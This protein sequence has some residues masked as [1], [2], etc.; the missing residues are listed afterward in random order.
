MPLAS[1]ASLQWYGPGAGAMVANEA[2]GSVVAGVK[3]TGRAN[4]VTTGTGSM[5]LA[6]AT[7]LVNSP[8][9]V[10]G[11]GSMVRA[12]PK[13]YGRPA[14]LMKIGEL[15]QDDVTGAVL[16]A[17]VE[18]TM[19]LK[20]ALRLLLAHAAADASG[21]ESGSVVYKSIDGTKDRITGTYSAGT[22]TVTGRD[23]S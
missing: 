21:L 15:S 4:Q 19:T 23:V 16:E 6:K 11:S 17:P 10:S 2:A 13:A 20:Q 8:M 3:G 1:L 9:V 12:L 5:P 22:R 14:M 18:G 7:R